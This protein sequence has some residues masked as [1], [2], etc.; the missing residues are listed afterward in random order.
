LE[1]G[2]GTGRVLRVLLEKGCRVTGVDISDDML[3]VAEAKLCE[4]LVQG[5]LVL[6]NHDFR[7]APLQEQYDRILVTFFTFNYLLTASEQQQFLLN[8]RQSLQANGVVI[9]DLFYPQPLAFPATSDEWQE[10]VL[11]A[12]GHQITLR[13]KRKMVGNIEAR[14]QIFADETHQ[15]EIV[16]QRCY[17]SKRQADAL[18]AQTGFQNCQVSDGYIESAFHPVA[19]AETTNSA[20]V[21]M[22][23]KPA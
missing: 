20:F 17:V 19:K 22:A 6:K 10:T 1:I 21:C 12:D 7:F 4:H 13:Q 5:K 14:I 9:I 11:H 3:R 8:V 16:T 2:C 15:D 18:L 23:R